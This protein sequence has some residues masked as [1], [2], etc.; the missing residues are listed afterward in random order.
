MLKVTTALYGDLYL[1]AQP[2]SDQASEGLEF[3]T[4][5]IASYTNEHEE[6]NQMRALPRQSLAYEYKVQYANTMQTWN[7]I[8]AGLRLKWAVPLWFEAQQLAI[9]SAQTV[10]AVDTTV[11][12]IR[13]SSLVLLYTLRGEWQLLQVDNITDN[14]VTTTTG[15]TLNGRAFIMGVRVGTVSGQAA[16]KP[17]GRDNDVKITYFIDDVAPGLSLA[18]PQYNGFDLETNPYDIDDTA[19]TQLSQLDTQLEYSTGNVAHLS[20]QTMPRY[21]STRQWKGFSVADLHAL[22]CWFYRRAGRFRPFYSPTF[23][24]NAKKNSTGIVANVFKIVDDGYRT[25]VWPKRKDLAF[26]L[27]DGSWLVRN[28][29]A[30]TDLGAG[31]TQV[32]LDTALNIDAGDIRVVSYASLCRLDTDRLE[33]ALRPNGYSSTSYSVLEVGS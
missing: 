24:S 31:I 20:P 22:R 2:P 8:A 16:F 13:A 23:E 21:S 18:M 12:D 26:G 9:A 29:T 6:R 17:S 4:D 10:F 15:T 11:H 3:F 28:A 5:V 27:K 1:V 33:I 19:S 30:A 14:T 32:T 25:M 7:A